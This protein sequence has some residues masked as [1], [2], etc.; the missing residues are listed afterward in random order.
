MGLEGGCMN[1]N[2]IVD[3][4]ETIDK[5]MRSYIEENIDQIPDGLMEEKCYQH[6]MNTMMKLS[7]GT[8]NPKMIEFLIRS[9]TKVF[10]D[11]NITHRL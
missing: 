3:I 6:T 4:A 2:N 7:R 8:I 1:R 5:T 10:I 9:H 11:F